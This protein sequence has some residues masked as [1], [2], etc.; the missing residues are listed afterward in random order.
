MVL[1]FRVVSLRFQRTLMNEEKM[2]ISYLQRRISLIEPR[3][4]ETDTLATIYLPIPQNLATNYSA[5]YVTEDLGFLGMKAAGAASVAM[6]G[7]DNSLTDASNW[8]N[9]ALNMLAQAVESGG[10]A[11]A[12]G[13]LI[14]SVL[15]GSTASTLVGCD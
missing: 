4:D 7:T 8:F 10:A 15:K 13:G 14:G 6:G 3:N 12:V 1:S 9:G 2:K 5:D 11:V